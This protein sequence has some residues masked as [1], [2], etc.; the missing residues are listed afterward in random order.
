MS[1]R[2][3][4]L[5]SSSVVGLISLASE[6]SR[7]KVKESLAMFDSAGIKYKIAPNAWNANEDCALPIESRISDLN[8]F[9]RDPEIWG[10]WAMRGGYGSVQLLA[11]V[12]YQL[13]RQTAKMFIGFSDI[14][15]LQW[16]LFTK[17][18][19]ISLSGL[20][21]T[22]QVKPQNPYL[23]L[24]LKLLRGGK[25]SLEQSDIVDGSLR[26]FQEGETE[27]VL[28]GGTL[29]VICSLCG[30]EYLPLNC[31]KVVL[32]VEDVNEPLYKIDRYIQQL[33]LSGF[34]EKLTGLI[35]GKFTNQGREIDIM[36]LLKK[37]IPDHMPV[38]QNFPYG[39]I[40]ASI[41]LPIGAKAFLKTNPFSLRWDN[42]MF[43]S[44]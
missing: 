25:N 26:V 44:V 36:P 12:D 10:I 11:Y 39:H 4:P 24:A 8:A 1:S 21:L 18:D 23:K 32:F 37:Y 27:G 5:T 9:L 13:V 15:A 20:A 19:L 40:V 14:T 28:L 2:F 31:G 43:D 35:I 41:P 17:S 42:F 22:L 33:R 3:R 6:V 34:W 7:E 16:A 29:S 30:T 38:I